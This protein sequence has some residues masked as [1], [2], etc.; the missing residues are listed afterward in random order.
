MTTAD[1][2]HIRILESQ[3]LS[4][5]NEHDL[6]EELVRRH[7]VQFVVQKERSCIGWCCASYCR[8]E[9]ELLRLV[10]AHEWRRRGIA[11]A[12]LQKTVMLLDRLGVVHLFL[13]VRAGNRAARQFYTKNRFIVAG[14]RS[15]Y[16]RQPREDALMMRS[17]ISRKT[18]DDKD[19]EH[20]RL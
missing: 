15:A 13:E 17:T 14:K 9:A 2:E 4:P 3:E 1:I 11:T 10:V 7:G 12:L 8:D 18:R 19:E 16:Y 6:K 5:W 20:T